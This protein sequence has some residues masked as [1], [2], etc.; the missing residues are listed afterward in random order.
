MGHWASRFEKDLKRSTGM[1]NNWHKG[2]Y[3]EAWLRI[4]EL[5]V[6]LCFFV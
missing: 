5:L 2:L 4:E 3:N 1:I 6:L